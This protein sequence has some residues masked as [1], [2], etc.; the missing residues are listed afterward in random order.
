MLIREA[1]IE[2]LEDLY[3]LLRQMAGECPHYGPPIEEKLMAVIA[4]TILNGFCIVTTIDKIVIGSIGAEIT[5]FYHNHDKLIMDRWLYVDPEYRNTRSAW[6]MMR[7][8]ATWADEQEIPMMTAVMS[9]LNID[10][11]DRLYERNKFRRIGSSYYRPVGGE[12]KE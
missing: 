11:T 1:T 12:R 9:G 7:Q 6:K 10:R 3:L 4:S 5:T 2:D 8:L